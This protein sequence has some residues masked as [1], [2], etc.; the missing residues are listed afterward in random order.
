MESS[1]P[2]RTALTW[3]M[4]LAGL[5]LV[6]LVAS[7]LG[8]SQPAPAAVGDQLLPDL[9]TLSPSG[10]S[11]GNAKR[12]TKELR[13][14]YSAANTGVGVL[15]LTSTSKDCD[16]DGV[17]SNDRTATQRIFTD[18]DG[19][20]YFTRNSDTAYDTQ[21]VGC[22]VFHPKHHHWHL[23]NF[24]RMS[25]GRGTN[26]AHRGERYPGPYRFADN[27]RTNPGPGLVDEQVLLD[28]Q[29]R[30]GPGSSIGWVDGYR[31]QLDGQSIEFGSP[32]ADT[33]A[34]SCR[35]P[36]PRT[37]SPRATIRTQR[38][39]PGNNQRGGGG[40]GT[41]WRG[42]DPATVEKRGRWGARARA[43]RYS[44]RRQTATG[45]RLARWC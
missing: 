3:I 43:A 13:F 39:N 19:N 29:P 6:G 27:F 2:N 17:Q 23:E 33:T 1:R 10:L 4:F 41:L 9:V 28:L 42:E 45:G 22:F 37:R 18:S 7:M 8:R 40:G 44:R 25:C 5:V 34:A 16:G 31:L 32:P 21:T 36:T 24:A 11:I 26:T 12:K 35:R 30:Q 38:G 14:A 20:G 15:E